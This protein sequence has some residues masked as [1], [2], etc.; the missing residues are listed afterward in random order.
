MRWC[1]NGNYRIL[2]FMKF[3]N[4][5]KEKKKFESRKKNNLQLR[6]IHTINGSASASS[7]ANIRVES[8]F[9]PETLENVYR[10]RQYQEF[11]ETIF[12]PISRSFDSIC[13]LHGFLAEFISS[14]NAISNIRNIQTR[15]GYRCLQ[16]FFPSAIWI[17]FINRHCPK[18]NRIGMGCSHFSCGQISSRNWVYKLRTNKKNLWNS[19]PVSEWTNL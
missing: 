1:I 10:D 7:F 9:D 3:I 5:A 16:D 14:H 18:F 8:S 15:E 2:L 11:R 12:F 4:N 13:S 19:C 17:E 6:L